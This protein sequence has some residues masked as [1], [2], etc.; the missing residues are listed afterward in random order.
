MPGTEQ[1]VETFVP[2]VAGFGTSVPDPI[3]APLRLVT[4]AGSLRVLGRLRTVPTFAYTYPASRDTYDDLLLTRLKLGVGDG[5]TT[6][7]EGTMESEAMPVLY[8]TIQITDGEGLITD[9][10]KHL[11]DPS[12]DDHVATYDGTGIFHGDGTGEVDYDTG[13]LSVTF[14]TAPPAGR[15][16]WVEFLNLKHS[17]VA[18]GTTAPERSSR[19]TR[20]QLVTTNATGVDAVANVA[21]TDWS[22][23]LVVTARPAQ[24]REVNELI[25]IE[26]NNNRK[27]GNVFLD[28]GDIMYGAQPANVGTVNV[29]GTIYHRIRIT[30]GTVWLHGDVRETPEADLH[31]A[32]VGIETI[33]LRIIPSFITEDDDAGLKSPVS[34]YETY[35]EPGAYR[36]RINVQWRVNDDT[37]V[38]VFT[39]RDGVPILKNRGTRFS[40]IERMVARRDYEIHGNFKVRGFR[41]TIEERLHDNGEVDDLNMSI[42]VDGGVAYVR[43]REINTAAQ[44]NLL[45]AK[46]RDTH[47]IADGFQYKPVGGESAEIYH[48]FKRPVAR[49]EKVSGFARTPVMIVTRA[50]SGVLDNLP[51]QSV[52]LNGGQQGAFYAKIPNDQATARILLFDNDPGE[53]ESLAPAPDYVEGVN[54]TIDPGSGDL[55][56]WTLGD[57]GPGSPT[58]G[59]SYYAYWTYDTDNSL[60]DLVK[61]TRLYTAT[62][63][64]LTGVTSPGSDDLLQKDIAEIIRVYNTNSGAEYVEGIDYTYTSGRSPTSQLAG[65]G[66][67]NFLS[68][69]S[70]SGNVTVEFAY[71]DHTTALWDTSHT[72]SAEGD[73]TDASS[74]V[75]L[76][77]NGT[78]EFAAAPGNKYRIAYEL[79]PEEARNAVDFRC[80][81]LGHSQAIFGAGIGRSLAIDE[82]GPPGNGYQVDLTFR[83]FLPRHDAVVLDSNGLV[84]VYYGQSAEQPRSPVV[85]DEL[86]QLA[87]IETRANST[88]PVVLDSTTMRSTMAEIQLM[89]RRVADLEANVAT[90]FLE[91]DALDR[92]G[93]AAVRGTYV[94]PFTDFDL[95]DV[96]FDRTYTHAAPANWTAATAY[97]VGDKVKN[98]AGGATAATLYFRCVKSGT[99]EG[100]EPTWDQDV[101]ERTA[102]GDDLIW[103][104]YAKTPFTER[105]KSMVA[106][107]NMASF[108]T[109]PFLND[110]NS[111]D[112]KDLVDTAGSSVYLGGQLVLLQFSHTRV[113]N[114]PFATRTELVNPYSTFRPVMNVTL[115]PAT[116]FWVDEKQGASLRAYLPGATIVNLSVGYERLRADDQQQTPKK[117]PKE[118]P[119]GRIDGWQNQFQVGILSGFLGTGLQVTEGWNTMINEVGQLA[120]YRHDL[121]HLTDDPE[122]FIGSG[123]VPQEI[124]ISTHPS[125]QYLGDVVVNT[126]LA[127]F[128]RQRIVWVVGE[129]FPIGVDV[130]AT[131]A[132][133]PIQLFITPEFGDYGLTGNDFGTVRPVTDVSSP[134]YGGFRADFLVPLS[135]PS[136]SAEVELNAGGDR[137]SATYIS[138]GTINTVASQYITVT[139]TVYDVV[140]SLCP[141]AQSFVAPR[142]GYVSKVHLYFYSKD[143]VKGIEVQI[144]NMVNGYPGQTVLGKKT[145]R[146]S[147]VNVSD[148]S[149]VATVVAFKDPVYV[150]KDQEYAICILDDSDRYRV[151]VAQLGHRDILSGNMVTRNN[152]IGVFFLSA[153]NTTWTAAQDVDM[154]YQLFFCHFPSPTGTL[155]VNQD[156]VLGSRFLLNSTQYAPSGTQIQWS[157]QFDNTGVWVP[158][159]IKTISRITSLF[160]KVKLRAVLVGAASDGWVISPA[161]NLHH[162][163]MNG[164]AYTGLEAPAHLEHAG[165][166]Y[167]DYV[168]ENRLVPDGLESLRMITDEWSPDVNSIVQAYW[169]VDDAQTWVPYPNAVEDSVANVAKYRRTFLGEGIYDVERFQAF[170]PIVQPTITAVTEVNSGGTIG[171][172]TYLIG[173]SLTTSYGESLMCEPASITISGTDNC[174]SFDLPAE[175]DWP[176]SLSYQNGK[177]V[178]VTGIRVYLSDPGGDESTMK[179]LDSA[180]VSGTLD[181]DETITVDAVTSETPTTNPPE[182]NTTVPLQFRTRI[183]LIAPKVEDYLMDPTAKVSGFTFDQTGSLAQ[184]TH[185]SIVMTWVANND[186]LGIKETA[187]SPSLVAT[188]CTTPASGSADNAIYVA[189]INFS[190]TPEAIGARLYIEQVGTTEKL[191]TVKVKRD[192]VVTEVTT[193]LPTDLG[194]NDDEDAYKIEAIDSSGDNPPGD[195][196]TGALATAVSQVAN[197]RVIATDGGT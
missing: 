52:E 173:Y 65:N 110:V 39:L 95:Q 87:S 38:P 129:L 37:S 54:F 133:R 105:V 149:H 187:P 70:A 86:L 112:I 123:F 31:V 127:P 35:G 32:G 106:I 171:A 145:L 41:V 5:S 51:G 4:Q 193:I 9:L 132:G 156:T 175:E 169:S 185:H 89:K 24:S 98:V 124:R 58:P 72:D 121:N 139:T 137:R 10:P 36:E 177:S 174:I 197:L 167:A 44:T 17:D 166:V 147:Q 96:N 155:L 77:V 161:L 88:V 94:D 43:G 170:H 158:I 60:F 142:S 8:T 100:S 69:G 144:R 191:A 179:L 119:L 78:I 16:V 18:V 118:V 64:A 138:H 141:V 12:H 189:L 26:Q 160:R 172:G 73:Y 67:I 75:Q 108:I 14:N 165:S 93:T 91:K 63:I 59:N 115:D 83:Y 188:E 136:G 66:F 150:V 164:M 178:H 184:N 2:D 195:N 163:G 27:L 157:V 111:E 116:D 19:A 48:L 81:G 135:V 3:G 80:L 196:E 101:G 21:K 25:S 126:A 120:V 130:S 113:I 104:L 125:T 146:P 134:F 42:D 29:G 99:S 47:S 168:S 22:R 131:F 62:S 49:V 97:W 153:N 151:W 40:D 68:G 15:G 159:E 192:G 182:V 23:H 128:M 50:T 6:V 74:Y 194:V 109:H 181:F 45:W 61:G 71:W 102:D 152:E 107:S 162:L 90:T 57:G 7:F 20:L 190:L 1:I 30:P 33:G 114:Q 117:L 28:D 76:V 186:F 85:P 53:D 79:V 154:K 13:G 55:I 103:V 11:L 122:D 46:A 34:G 82:V 56:D 143:T 84:T 180:V 148:N 183:K 176:G 92:L 140:G